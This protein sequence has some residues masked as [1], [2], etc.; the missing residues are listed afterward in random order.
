MGMPAIVLLLLLACASPRIPA[1][2]MTC[3]PPPLQLSS[4]DVPAGQTV[5]VSSGAFQCGGSYPAGK[6]YD[7]VLG[8][9]RRAK[10]V[11]LGSYPVS[12]NGSFQ[13]IVRIPNTAPPGSAYV[14]VKGSPFDNCREAGASCASY[15]A[16][17]TVR[18]SGVA[19]PTP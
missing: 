9:F 2:G 14:M 3:Y 4:G 19:T 6:K 11:D 16:R 7:L 10:G 8:L 18:P 5:I 17:L 1:P 13:A 15:I 12:T